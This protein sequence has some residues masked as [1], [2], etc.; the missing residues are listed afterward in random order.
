M[1]RALPQV[2]VLIL[3][4]GLVAGGPAFAANRQ[5]DVGSEDQRLRRPAL[6]EP[7]PRVVIPIEIPPEG[8]LPPAGETTPIPVTRVVLDGATRL[9]PSQ[10]ERFTASAAGKTMTL[11][12]LQTLARNITR[13]YRGRGYITSRAVVP[14]QPVESGVIHV[15]VIEGKLGQ[16]AIEGN[17]YVSD[18]TLRRALRVEPGEILW[19]PRLESALRGLNEHRDRTVRLVLSPGQAPETTDVLLRVS[20]HVPLHAGYTVD[21]LGTK[22][23]GLIRHTLNASTSNFSGADD[24]LA[25]RGILSEFGGLKAGVV[26]YSRPLLASG[27]AATLSVSGVKSSVGGDLKSLDATGSAVTINPGLTMPLVRRAQ[28]EVTAD[29]GFDYTRIRTYLGDVVSSK[30]DLRV[31][32]IGGQLLEED[33]WGRGAISDQLRVGIPVIMGGSHVK[34]IA[35]SRGG[36]GGS[37]VAWMLNILRLQRGPFGTSILARASTQVASDRLVPAEQFRLGGFDTV[38]GYP[39]GEYLADYGYQM[40]WEWRVPL[41]WTIPQSVASAAPWLDSTRRTSHAALFWDFAEGWLRAPR[42]NE[43]GQTRLSGIGFGIRARPTS[44]SLVQVDL[45][46]PVGDPASEKHQPR[47]HLTVTIGF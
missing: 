9:P 29:T 18:A 40:S 2:V 6:L 39:E 11:A 36:A 23:T 3:L 44:E 30:D 20:D 1:S 17:R 8:E 42:S 19:M 10:A 12:E 31:A 35:A 15:R 7:P 4:A 41:G 22:N 14:A 47:V 28:W 34:D 21:T 16:V 38:R 37:F 33:R 25:A 45:G 24:E 43:D 26:S 27:L 46:W 32:H 5:T 13:W